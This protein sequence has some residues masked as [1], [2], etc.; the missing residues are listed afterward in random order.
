M[1]I[2]ENIQEPANS[3]ENAL[4]EETV[5]LAQADTPKAEESSSS[6]QS[7]SPSSGAEAAA[8]GPS[9]IFGSVAMVPVA[10]VGIQQVVEKVTE[11]SS[12][13]YSACRSDIAYVSRRLRRS[14]KLL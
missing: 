12:A 4:D 14:K 2:K 3:V 10:A 8:T 13:S 9:S 7:S 5:E 11:S 6:N 1:E